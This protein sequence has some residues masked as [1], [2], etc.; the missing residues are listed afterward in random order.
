MAIFYLWQ[1]YLYQIYCTCTIFLSADPDLGKF[2]MKKKEDL[3]VRMMTM[4]NSGRY[5][6]K[7]LKKYEPN[8]FSKA[9]A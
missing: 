2:W 4:A 3:Y 1:F 5:L 7:S 6:C 8:T 9:F